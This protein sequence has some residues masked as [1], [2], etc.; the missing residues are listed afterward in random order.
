MSSNAALLLAARLVSAGTTLALLTFLGHTEGGSALGVAAVGL[1]MGALLSAVTDAG[2]ASLMIR[3][4][5]RDPGNLGRLLV[6]MSLW[7]L[8]VAPVG[9][10]VLWLVIVSAVSG[11]PV[12]V[13][14]LALGLMVQQFAELTRAVFIA[15]QEMR[16]SSIHSTLE[17]I[18]WLTSIVVA[19]RTGASLETA[20][21]VGIGVFAVSAGVGFGLVITSGTRPFGLPD[22]LAIRRLVRQL[23]PFA[24]FTVVG[25]GYSRVDTLLVG[26]LLPAGG[27]I[28]AGAYFSAMRLLAAAEYVPEAVARASYP[29]VARAYQ[30]GPKKIAAEL[31]PT[32]AFLLAAGMSV[33]MVLVVGGQWIMATLFG[34]D[35]VPYAW[36]VA[37][38][39]AMVPLRFLSHLFGMTLT[40]TDAQGRRV[41]AVVIALAL[42]L[43]VDIVLI[44]L[45]G[46]G[47]AVIGSLVASLSVFVAYAVPIVR[48]LGQMN[49]V[50]VGVRYGVLS[51][52]LGLIGLA[53]APAL[54]PPAT[55]VL[56]LAGYA[57]GVVWWAPALGV[58]NFLRAG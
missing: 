50:G 25:V 32:A 46:I 44:P 31:R 51:V 9:A 53:I 48:Q 19:L 40:S 57:A 33:P 28:G 20:F 29:R 37:P 13:F 36:I 14:L 17:N 7:R 56:V 16:V 39:G 27:I 30:L 55:V 34:P 11:R 3:E 42:V 49:L 6:A 1:A 52:A 41:V 38:L 54:G 47:G 8:A 15:R 18:G 23:G 35:V 58:S 2:T 10:A 21:A 5:S 4:G 12:A 22:G 45:V 26:A 43:G 24:A